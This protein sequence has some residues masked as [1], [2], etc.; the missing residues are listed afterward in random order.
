MSIRF[1]FFTSSAT[2]SAMKLAMVTLSESVVPDSCFHCIM[3]SCCVI[4]GSMP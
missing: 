2:P 3:G 1:F 4:L